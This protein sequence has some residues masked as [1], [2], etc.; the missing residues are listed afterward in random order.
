[1]RDR[2]LSTFSRR[3]PI[4]AQFVLLVGKS[5]DALGVPEGVY[6]SLK[7]CPPG[8]S[9]GWS[10][11]VIIP[12][13]ECGFYRFYDELTGIRRPDLEKLFR[14]ITAGDILC[15][16]STIP[17]MWKGVPKTS[18]PRRGRIPKKV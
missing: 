12:D 6:L 4:P 16:S 15:L 11:I 1:M 3:H 17:Q 10:W 2:T 7:L 18:L 5:A 8:S 9:S 14:G 13:A